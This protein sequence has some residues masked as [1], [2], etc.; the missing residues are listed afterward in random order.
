VG[1]A[2]HLGCLEGYDVEDDAVG[3]KEHVQ[4]ALEVVFGE[5]VGEAA[6]VEAADWG[7]Y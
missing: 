6:N 3:G 7:Q 5:L 4:A 1:L 2:A